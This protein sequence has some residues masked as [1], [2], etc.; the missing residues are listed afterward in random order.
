MNGEITTGILKTKANI[1]EL[2]ALQQRN[3]KS[4]ISSEELDSQGFVTVEHNFE[5]LSIMQSKLPQIVAYNNNVVVG[6]ALSMAVSCKNIIP[7]LIPMFELLDGLQYNGKQLTESKY[8]VMG[9]I[10]IDK[11]LRGH[12]IFQKL[13]EQHAIEFAD[14]FDFIITEVSLNNPRSMKAH[15][16]VGFKTIHEYYDPSNNDTWAVILWDLKKPKAI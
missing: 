13:Y 15:Y 11:S 5:K 6:Y 3:L 8:Y 4:N 7:E 16:K 9:Q 12:G 1:Y 10:C 2:L 14:K